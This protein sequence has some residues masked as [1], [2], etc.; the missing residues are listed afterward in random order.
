MD[1]LP[2]QGCRGLCCGPVPITEQELRKIKKKVK[3]MPAKIR[4]SLRNQPRHYGTCMFYDLDQDRCG[5]HSVRP[6]ICRAFGYHKNLVCFRN[7]EAATQGE[8]I[9]QETHIGLLTWDITWKDFD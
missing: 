5:I 7:P 2:C 3:S 1:K 9:A 6:E 4:S 8:W